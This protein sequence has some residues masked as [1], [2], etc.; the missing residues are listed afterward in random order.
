[1][2]YGLEEFCADCHVDLMEDAGPKGREKVRHNLER[3]LSDPEEAKKL[4]TAFWE[5]GTN[6][7]HHDTET[8]IYVLGH[9][10]PKEGRRGPHDHGSSWAIYSNVSG[11]TDMTIWRRLDDGTEAGH[12]EIEPDQD[13]RVEPGMAFLYNEGAIHSISYPAGA[14]LI[15][16]TG[17]DFNLETVKRFDPEKQA[18][19]IHDRSKDSAAAP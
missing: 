17:T 12:A 11:H 18:V 14:R 7:I 16:I 19:I 13:Y 4:R 8:G 15:R 3:L 6:I 9:L 5:Q 1:M 2:S 10:H